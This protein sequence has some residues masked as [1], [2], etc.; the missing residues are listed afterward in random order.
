LKCTSVPAAITCPVLSAPDW[1]DLNCSH[2]HGVFAFSST[3]AFSCQTGFVLTGSETRECTATGTWTGDFPRC[4]G[5]AAARAQGVTG[6]GV[7][8]GC[9]PASWSQKVSLPGSCLKRASSPL[10]PSH[11]QRWPPPRWAMLPAPTSMGTLPSDPPVPSPARQ[12][13]C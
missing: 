10:Q 2:L 5:S 7:T 11:A 4:E 12:G 1:G 6:L 13:L 9:S 3:C 8:L